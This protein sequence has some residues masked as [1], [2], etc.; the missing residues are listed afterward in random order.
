MF[1]V[2]A[3]RA[4]RV[5]VTEGFSDDD[6]TEVVPRDAALLAAGA[7]VI[8]VGNREIEDGAEV[9]EETVEPT[10]AAMPERAAS[11]AATTEAS[12]G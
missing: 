6:A 4:R 2:E 12:K 8:V 1:V 5:E 10:P 7:R 3:N 9:Q 11:E